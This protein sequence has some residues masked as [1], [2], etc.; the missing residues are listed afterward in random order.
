M[1]IAENDIFAVDLYNGYI[2]WFKLKAKKQLRIIIF[3]YSAEEIYFSLI[4]LPKKSL[5]LL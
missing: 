3:W 4:I 5:E 2:L 1:Q